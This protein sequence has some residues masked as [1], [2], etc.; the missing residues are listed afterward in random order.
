M[1]RPISP[2]TERDIDTLAE[3][4]PSYSEDPIRWHTPLEIGGSNGSHHSGTLAKLA[5]RG[6]IF[7]NQRGLGEDDVSRIRH[8]RGS[9]WYK[10]SPEGIAYLKQINRWP[11]FKNYDDWKAWFDTNRPEAAYARD[12]RRAARAG[13]A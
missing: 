12:A 3:L 10:L 1:A 8:A 7:M 11:R 5:K 4:A 9:K 6:L 2:L 13:E